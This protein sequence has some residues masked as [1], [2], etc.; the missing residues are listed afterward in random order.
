M[1]IASEIDRSINMNENIS[2]ILNE[3][4]ALDMIK[5]QRLFVILLHAINCNIAKNSAV[6]EPRANVNEQKVVYINM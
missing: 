5:W 6:I 1:Y 4:N 2:Y 3:Y